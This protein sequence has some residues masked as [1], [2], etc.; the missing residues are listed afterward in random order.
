MEEV[1][2]LKDA[3]G[4]HDYQEVRK[5]ETVAL[6]MA[7]QSCTVQLGTPLGVLCS[8]VQEVCQC[9]APLIEEGCL[10]KLEMLDVVEKNPM[11]PTP[12]SALSSPTPD[13]EEEQVVLT[14]EESCT[15]EPEESACLEGELTL[16]WG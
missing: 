15:S 1:P 3:Q 13:P 16:V 8:V 11:A 14:P 12:G 9:L 2:P 7:L 10:L 4:S 5:E 6:A